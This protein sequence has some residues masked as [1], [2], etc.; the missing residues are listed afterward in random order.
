M[1]VV[2]LGT[3]SENVVSETVGPVSEDGWA[4]VIWMQM[5]HSIAV[6]W[7]ALQGPGFYSTTTFH[8]AVFRA[9]IS[10]L[11]ESSATDAEWKEN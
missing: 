3:H 1:S 7:I 11:E 2:K 9:I 4:A 6:I 10:F 5:N 8:L